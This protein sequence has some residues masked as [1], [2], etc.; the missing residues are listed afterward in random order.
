MDKKAKSKVRVSS[1]YIQP[2]NVA[3]GAHQESA[4]S[5]LLFII[6]ME[7]LLPKFQVECPWELLYAND[8]IIFSEAFDEMERR[9]KK[10]KYKLEDKALKDNIEKTKV[11]CSRRDPPKIKIISPVC[12]AVVGENLTLNTSCEE[13]VL[14]RCSGIN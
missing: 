1:N 10:W 12:L 2:V 8:L 4:L 6:V 11:I 13:W 3:V 7:A 14:K 9:L 5:P